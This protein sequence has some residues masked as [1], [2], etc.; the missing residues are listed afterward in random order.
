M[1]DP[2]QKARTERLAK[3]RDRLRNVYEDPRRWNNEC[4]EIFS[5]FRI[6][7]VHLRGQKEAL[8]AV[9]D[10]EVVWR[11]LCKLCRSRRPFWGRCEEVVWR[12]LCKLCRSRRPF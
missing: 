12:F 8:D 10:K 9:E 4:E 2:G 1:T 7:V 11:F 3:A 6:A 5:E